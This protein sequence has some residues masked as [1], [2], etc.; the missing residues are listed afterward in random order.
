MKLVLERKHNAKIRYRDQYIKVTIMKENTDERF[1]GNFFYFR[2]EEIFGRPI[3]T[4]LIN[5][6]GTNRFIGCTDINK[7]SLKRH[8]DGRL[9]KCFEG[10]FSDI[11]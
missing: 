7:T 9:L 8:F 1:A 10:I 4:D 3:D 2:V 5:I 11:I 6:L